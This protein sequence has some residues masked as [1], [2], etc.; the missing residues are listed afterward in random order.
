MEVIM[1][2]ESRP[3]TC[4]LLVLLM[5]ASAWV[6]SLWTAVVIMPQDAYVELLNQNKDLRFQNHAIRAQVLKFETERNDRILCGKP[7]FDYALALI[8]MNEGVYS[9]DSDDRGKETVYGITRYWVPDHPIW[10]EVDRIKLTSKN[11]TSDLKNSPTIQR[12][13]RN[14]YRNIW[15]TYGLDQ[16]PIQF[17]TTVFDIMVN[18]GQFAA[19]NMVQKA[20]NSLNYNHRFGSDL[21]VDGIWGKHLSKTLAQI[22]EY[23]LSDKLTMLLTAQKTTHYMGLANNKPSQ[24]KFIVGWL[25]R[26]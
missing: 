8:L 25:S 10:D 19:I 4:I 24:R 21:I 22:M 26:R 17:S 9:N 2:F 1:K 5:I 7:P 14:W 12:Q 16:Y 13:V 23:G 20:A 6:Y 11:L 15:N 3:V 18:C